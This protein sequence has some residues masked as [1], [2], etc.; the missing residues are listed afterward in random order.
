MLKNS[1]ILTAVLLTLTLSTARGQEYSIELIDAAPDA[2]DVSGEL[3]GQFADRGVRVKRGSTRTACEIWFCKQWAVEAGFKATDERLYPFSP[4]QLIGLLHFNRRNSDF[5]NQ[6]VG[7]GWYTLRF[8]LQPVDGNH[9]GT[10]PTRD[11]LVMIDAEQDAPDKQWAMKD[12]E[13]A[14]AKVAGSSH[15][16]ML[17]L[18]RATEGDE[19]TI[20]HEEASDRW[21]L[22]VVGQGTADAKTQDVPV[23]LIVVGHAAE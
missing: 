6:T 8:G 16:A 19:S 1:S 13:K 18:Q 10:S 20:R 2:D 9:V 21:I 14:S 17:C 4:G 3:A 11:F 12:L 22:H 5:R 15:P 7:S 23:D